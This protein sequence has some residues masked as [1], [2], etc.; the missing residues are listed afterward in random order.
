MSSTNDVLREDVGEGSGDGRCVA[1]RERNKILLVSVSM[2][3]SCAPADIMSLADHI[4]F[5]F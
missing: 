2:S 4:Y 3:I 5:H 1:C